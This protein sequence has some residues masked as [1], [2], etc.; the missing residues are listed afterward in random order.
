VQDNRITVAAMFAF[1]FDRVSVD[2]FEMQAASTPDLDNIVA[3]A[4]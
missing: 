4:I 2:D 3:A 1:D